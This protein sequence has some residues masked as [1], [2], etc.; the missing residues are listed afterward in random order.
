MRNACAAY[1]ACRR[2]APTPELWV[3]HGRGFRNPP[4]AAEG[5]GSSSVSLRLPL[6]TDASDPEY[7]GVRL[8]AVSTAPEYC[9]VRLNAVSTAPEYCGVRL[10]A[11]STAPEYCGV[12]LNAVSTAPEYCGVRLNAVSTA[13]EY[14]G[15]RLNAVSTAP[16]YCG[17]RLNAVSTAPEYCGVRLNAVSTAP[18]YCGVR[19]N[20]TSKEKFLPLVVRA[21]SFLELAEDKYYTIKC[22]LQGFKNARYSG[23]IEKICHPGSY[24]PPGLFLFS[25]RVLLPALDPAHGVIHGRGFRNPPCAAEGDGSSSVSLRL[26]LITDASDPEYCG[27]RLNATSK[28]K[29]LPLVVRAHSFLELAEDK[30][31]TI[32]CGLQGFKN[33]RNESSF[34]D[35]Q[36]LDLNHRRT[37]EAVFSRQYLLHAAIAG[38]D[39]QHAMRVRSCFS[40]GD[41]NTTVQLTDDNGCPTSEL[42][43]WTYNDT[44]GTATATLSMWRFPD[45]NRVHL[46]CDLAI[47]RI[48]CGEQ[49]CDGVRSERLTTN[50]R[51]L[52][53]GGP[54][55][56]QPGVVKAATTV[57]VVDPSTSGQYRE[58]SWYPPWLWILAIALAV[59]FIIMMIINIFLCS[60]MTCSCTKT[61]VIE[62]EPSILEDYDPYRSSWHGSQCGSRYSLNGKTGYL[63]GA[64]TL[65]SARSVSSHSDHYAAIVHSRP[66]SRYS[67]PDSRHHHS[68]GHN[69][70]ANGHH[71]HHHSNGHHT[72]HRSPPSTTGSHY[73]N[74]I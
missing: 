69:H 23:A 24:M 45:T 9:G 47:C 50:G 71:H 7:C 12:R 61:S 57:F 49:Q 13:P 67:R 62:K 68:S 26:P 31:Y 14:C 46:Q 56:L 59:L 32:K 39:A 33:A 43:E 28:E 53:A 11:V 20:A 65:N 55:D 72:H 34:V 54:N 30:Y 15:V 74:R 1:E 48:P 18:E 66:D 70:S 6:I 8:N 10:N 4:C 2:D 58:C 41:P 17:V 64:S 3:I 16:E 35:L 27:V 42:S 73:S 52:E 51:A 63:S 25:T 60:A 40:F 22:G 21:H 36:L 29:F 5:D 19:L 44:A 38:P 37:S